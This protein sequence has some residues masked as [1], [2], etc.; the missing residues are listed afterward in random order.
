MSAARATTGR[1]RYPSPAAVKRAV[2]QVT[3]CALDVAGVEV[4][5]DGVIRILTSQAFAHPRD[6]FEAWEQAGKL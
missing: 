1:R 5:P 6:D 3:D 2:K 4:S